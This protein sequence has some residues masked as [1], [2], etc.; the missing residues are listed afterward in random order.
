M[1]RSGEAI[2]AGPWSNIALQDFGNDPQSKIK[3]G[4]A[5]QQNAKLPQSQH[6]GQ[7]SDA[8]GA[9]SQQQQTF[10]RKTERIGPDKTAEGPCRGQQQTQ[11][12]RFAQCRKPAAE[13][14]QHHAA[15]AQSQKGQTSQIVTAHGCNST[16]F[17]TFHVVLQT[18][19]IPAMFIG[20]KHQP[21]QQRTRGNQRPR[22]QSQPS[23]KPKR[24][25]R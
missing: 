12:H 18:R 16:L 21:N 5:H 1:Q 22:R 9:K 3:P 14:Q 11:S 24:A 25:A 23:R 13:Q 8:A 2:S 20:Q 15:A 10:D 17:G 4:D 19:S 7:T 6:A